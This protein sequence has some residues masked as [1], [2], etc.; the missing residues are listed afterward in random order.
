MDFGYSE[1]Q[2]LF[3]NSLQKLLSDSY[4]VDVRRKLVAE[5]PGYSEDIWKAYAEMG[6]LALPFPEDMGG[7]DGTSVDAMVVAIEL[8]RHLALEP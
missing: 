3:S 4:S 7:L 1:E 2:V 5:G 8:G 6:L